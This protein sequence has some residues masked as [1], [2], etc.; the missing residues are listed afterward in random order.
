M[1]LYAVSDLHIRDEHDP[2]YPPLLALLRER[3]MPGDQVVLAGDIFDVFVGDKPEFTERYA[4]FLRAARAAAARGV[5]V[6]YLEGNHD[7][8]LGRALGGHGIRVH[9][10]ELDRVGL[11]SAV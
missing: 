1:T 6:D 3:A 10:R 7:F 11:D 9:A 2:L 5:R 4:E 8:L